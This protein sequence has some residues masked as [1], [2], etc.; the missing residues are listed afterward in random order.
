[1][2]KKLIVLDLDGT[3]LKK[4]QT[5]S[6]RTKKALANAQKKGHEVMIATGRPYRMSHMYYHELGL[7]T[8]IVNFNGAVF[9]HPLNT[10]FSEA[11]HQ[12]I[13]LKN[14]TRTARFLNKLS[15]RQYRSRSTGQR[16]L[17][18]TK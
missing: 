7:H 2:T 15:V 12:A 9:H 8:P 14:S 4:D 10:Q 5:I 18:R 16:I 11:Y 6:N 3:T 17:T 1:M 13:D